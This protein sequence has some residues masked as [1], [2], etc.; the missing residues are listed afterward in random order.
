MNQH[1]SRQSNTT[2]QQSQ[3]NEHSNAKSMIAVP[4]L[5]KKH[6]LTEDPLLPQNSAS[7]EQQA[8]FP[9]A[10][11]TGNFT[12]Q[13]KMDTERQLSFQARPFQ[14]K[15]GV[16]GDISTS[17]QRSQAPYAY[18]Q[19]KANNTGLP[20]QLKTGVENLSAW[21]V[22]Q[23]KQSRVQAAMQMKSENQV[24]QF[25]RE[26]D[27]TLSPHKTKLLEWLVDKNKTLGLSQK[28]APEKQ[29]TAVP[30]TS[31]KSNFSWH[32][33]L[34]FAD[35]S[36]HGE[37]KTAPANHGGNLR[38]GPMAN[39]FESNDVG[40][41]TAIDYSYLPLN[42]REEIVLDSYSQGAFDGTVTASN[43]SSLTGRGGLS[44]ET[45][46]KTPQAENFVEGR[47]TD[48]FNEW[49]LESSIKKELLSKSQIS[50]LTGILSPNIDIFVKKIDDQFNSLLRT[51]K[52]YN[53]KKEV[54]T[55]SGVPITDISEG[56]FG[57]ISIQKGVGNIITASDVI[58]ELLRDQKWVK[59][60]SQ[61][62]IQDEKTTYKFGLASYPPF[63]T[64]I[65]DA[66]T[67]ID[68][69]SYGDTKLVEFKSELV[70]VFETFRETGK[71]SDD[72]DQQKENTMIGLLVNN[73]KTGAA[74]YDLLWNGINEANVKDQYVKEKITD[75]WW[76]F[77]VPE[78]DDRFNALTNPAK[79]ENADASNAWEATFVAM[80]SQWPGDIPLFT[81]DAAL[82]ADNLTIDFDAVETD[83]NDKEQSWDIK[84]INRE[85]YNN[86][87]PNLPTN[88][89]TN[90]MT[91]DQVKN[92][93][94]NK[95][96]E[97]RESYLS[98]SKE[99]L[100]LADV[101]EELKGGINAS[102]NVFSKRLGG[103]DKDLIKR[104][105]AYGADLEGFVNSTK[106]NIINS[107]KIPT[108]IA[109]TTGKKWEDLGDLQETLYTQW[110]SRENVAA[111]IIGAA[112]S[113]K[114]AKTLP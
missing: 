55:T 7:T 51:Y 37:G 82:E 74:S 61:G 6:E 101:K 11:P 27:A 25:A 22:A 106:W 57:H 73:L 45:H 9:P 59:R 98:N 94:V 8:A 16:S 35:L 87:K 68:L 114:F 110:L 88:F 19:K 93:I 81:E 99:E 70:D 48:A 112:T 69:T 29:A 14:L 75:E 17:A 30:S 39:R 41:G 109:G 52:Y 113:E 103:I 100:K 33:V 60:G 91:L 67:N 72:F 21:H 44:P 49:F 31:K 62:K 84:K 65:E 54:I 2:H 5:L 66:V 71:E 95:L 26:Y 105:A 3:A 86:S 23:Q 36:V 20:N 79:N 18:I 77:P 97:D 85:R 34:A 12:I 46:T 47:E 89:L 80:L 108:D 63:T 50:K 58:D 90:K 53:K 42:E 43:E 104:R 13:P 78:E 83:I 107:S 40:G 10:L 24:V 32:H 96:S 102:F 4:A 64:L 38:L 76:S 28:V 111:A 15:A 1:E 92:A 56:N